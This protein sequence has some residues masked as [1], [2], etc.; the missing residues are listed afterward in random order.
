LG[1]KPQAL[2]ALLSLLKIYWK[3]VSTGSRSK[4]KGLLFCFGSFVNRASRLDYIA[5]LRFSLNWF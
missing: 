1:V 3:I 4:L 2:Q 5:V